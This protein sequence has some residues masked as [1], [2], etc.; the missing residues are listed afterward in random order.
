MKRT[1]PSPIVSGDMNIISS[2]TSFCI[3]QRTSDRTLK[4]RSDTILITTDWHSKYEH[5]HTRNVCSKPNIFSH[6][7]RNFCQN[8]LVADQFTHSS[9]DL[10]SNKSKTTCVDL[11]SSSFPH[12]HLFSLNTD[13]YIDTDANNSICDSFHSLKSS[14]DENSSQN[15]S[16]I[17]DIFIRPPPHDPIT[18]NIPSTQNNI[19]PMTVHIQVLPINTISPY[20]SAPFKQFSLGHN[21]GF[22]K[23]P[24]QPVASKR[25]KCGNLSDESI[26]D[27]DISKTVTLS[28]QDSPNCSM[29]PRALPRHVKRC[30]VGGILCDLNFD[31]FEISNQNKFDSPSGQILVEDDCRNFPRRENVES[32]NILN[33]EEVNSSNSNLIKFESQGD[34]QLNLIPQAIKTAFGEFF[35]AEFEANEKKL[36]NIPP[37]NMLEDISK[38]FVSSAIEK[39]GVNSPM[40]ISNISNQLDKPSIVNARSDIENITSSTLPIDINSLILMSNQT[41][42]PQEN[43]SIVSHTS[44][45]IPVLNHPNSDQMQQIYELDGYLKKSV[46]SESD[47]NFFEKTK[48]YCRESCNIT[49]R[50]SHEQNNL[51]KY[52]FP[53]CE[54]KS[55]QRQC[56][57]QEESIHLEASNDLAEA[58]ENELIDPL[59]LLNSSDI[60]VQRIFG[61]ENSLDSESLLRGRAKSHLRTKN[62][63]LFLMNMHPGNEGIRSA[64][65]IEL[66]D[67]YPLYELPYPPTPISNIS[68]STKSNFAINPTCNSQ[69]NIVNCI[70]DQIPPPIPST[71]PPELDD[72]EF[73]FSTLSEN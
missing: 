38:R 22:S 73:H 52:P 25:N 26:S 50:Y 36:T 69:E 42:Q 44:L 27:Q 41:D 28:T 62:H 45:T 49:Q 64:R 71:A 12:I 47:N 19:D 3:P 57:L 9:V 34:T 31:G 39:C 4:S 67:H 40:T 16:E 51:I 35:I 56:L 13:I 63:N 7:S 8:T 20:L 1:L 32:S 61:K 23:V 10:T 46:S 68:S 6:P 29:P 58:F 70:I 59:H 60:F 2:F 48:R 30:E 14:F 53:L 43:D 72:T 5:L 17:D 15:L 33:S 21:V 18:A 24:Y 66:I 55:S 65:S 54:E 37:E 11:R